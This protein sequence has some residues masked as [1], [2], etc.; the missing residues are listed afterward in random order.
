MIDKLLIFLTIVLCL[1]SSVTLAQNKKTVSGIVTGE[2]GIPLVGVNVIEKGTS[3][4]TSTDF[5]GNYTVV[6]SDSSGILIFSSLGFEGKEI[7]INGKANINVTLATDSEQLGEVVVTAL[8]IKKTTKALGYSLT[9][10]GGEELSTIKLTNAVNSLQGKVAGVNVTQNSTGAAGS[11]RVIIRGSSSLTGNNQPLYVVDGIPI[12]NNNNG[13]AGLWGGSDG[14]DGISSINPDDIESVSV[15]KGGAA[16]ALY[17]SRAAGGVII[18][19]TKSGKEQKGFGVEISSSVTFDKVDTS[20]Q[21]FQTE[22][23]QGRRATKP[24]NQEEALDVGLSSWGERLDGSSVIQWDG[25]SRPYSYVGSNLDHFYRTGTTYINSVA[26]TNGGDNFNYRF[27]ASDL[28]NNDITPNSGLNRKTFSLNSGAVMAEKLTTQVNVKYVVEKVMNRPRLS[29]APG[30]GNFTV[31]NLSP[32]VDV[33]FMNPGA[34]EDLT[35][36]QYSSNTFSQNPYFAAY[37]FRNEDTKNRIIA[38]TS[39][40]YDI[41]DWF[42]V[43]GRAGVDHYTIRRTAVEP[44][45]TAYK[46]LGGIEEREIRYSQIDAD[47]ILGVEKNITD[48][49]ATNIFIGANGNS[50]SQ[51]T[52]ILRGND[53]IVPG[54]EQ[55]GNTVN[56]SSE[57]IFGANRDNPGNGKRKIGSL[58]GSVEFSYDSFAYLTFTGRNDWFST[59]SFPGKTTPND[60]FYS[61]VSASFILSEALELPEKIN[62]LK[63]RAGYSKV[64]GGA[65]DPYQ[66]ALTYEIF[67]QGHQGQPLGAIAGDQVPNANLVAFN[68]SEF[69]VGLDAR[70]FNN[71]LSFDIA[72]YNNKTTNDIVPV[73]TS[74][75]SGYSRAL[76]NIGEVENKGIEFLISGTPIKT[77]NFSWETSINGA[78]N[79]GKVIATNK[80]DGEISLGEPR[81]RNVEIKQIVGEAYGTIFGVSYVRDDN[82]NIVYEIDGDGVP[83]AQRGERK[84][85]GEGVPPL[86]LGFTNTITY[87]N[88]ILNFLIDGKFGGQIF[89]GTNTVTYGNGLHKGTL[90]GRENGL[91]VT[92]VNAETG[93]QFTT[94]VAPEDLQTYYGRISQ[95]AEEFVEDSDY[96]KFRQLSLGY[97]FPDKLLDNTFLDSATISVIGSNLFYIMRTVD[98]IDPESAYNVGN[99]QGLEYFGLPSTR[100]YGLN[101]NLKF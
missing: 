55:F 86:T 77:E 40:R 82:G 57:N 92:G 94:T 75:F 85:L 32:N 3:N 36:R 53:F 66:L 89:S 26:L 71:R 52:K 19:T 100:S 68:K 65:Q 45:G 14:G 99:A 2:D 13:S 5:D 15:L 23:G 84:I 10:V 49:L 43:S 22:Y 1:S 38:S 96:I 87:K 61:S 90:A 63:L 7:A 56:Q 6:V 27:S 25:V 37:N 39:L 16:S 80:D 70:F 47:L 8:G 62:F 81:S 69:E 72:Y 64:A 88:L 35:E 41:L 28:S 78:H 48:R 76:A 4:G 34:N 31:S 30:N 12:S 54:L 97:S 58:Y 50:V 67:G 17:G 51:E 98:N 83:L 33:R 18:V 95:I 59:L 42:Y 9:E 29:D 11:S 60:D 73:G 20:L 24:V 46:P 44:F 91:T 79:S 21:D 93:E 101:V 74:V